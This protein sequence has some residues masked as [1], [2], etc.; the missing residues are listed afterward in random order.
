M[1]LH[2]G[3]AEF[4]FATTFGLRDGAAEDFESV[5]MEMQIERSGIWSYVSASEFARR[6]PGS[7]GG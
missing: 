5:R 3:A 1:P 2:P 6:R 7:L 4:H